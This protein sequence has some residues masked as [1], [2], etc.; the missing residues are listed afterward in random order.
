MI[1]I[2]QQERQSFIG[3]TT[4]TSTQTT[5]WNDGA[6]LDSITRQIVHEAVNRHR[7]IVFTPIF[8]YC[9]ACAYWAVKEIA[10]NGTFYFIAAILVFML[11]AL[12]IFRSD[13]RRLKKLESNDFKWKYD[14]VIKVKY[15]ASRY[16][17]SKVYTNDDAYKTGQSILSFRKGDKIIV[18]K[19]NTSDDIKNLK[20][21]LTY[22]YD[23]LAYKL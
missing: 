3:N 6:Q 18:I 23:P 12:I 19:Y 16:N 15:L 13:S 10:Y 5:E 9:T 8:L 2:M 1:P 14:E 17:P 7:F 20:A 22:L 21:N 11:V 4:I